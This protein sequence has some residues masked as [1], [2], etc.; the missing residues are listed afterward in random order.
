[1]HFCYK[2]RLEANVLCRN[3]GWKEEVGV[4]KAGMTGVWRKM[5]IFVKKN[6][7]QLFHGKIG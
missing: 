2:E 1:M 7:I 4:R 6:L 3:A 5:K